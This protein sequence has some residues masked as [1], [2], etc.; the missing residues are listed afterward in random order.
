M[1]QSCMRYIRATS[2]PGFRSLRRFR[3]DDLA[4]SSRLPMTTST[5]TRRTS[6]AREL[7]RGA[8]DLASTGSSVHRY[9]DPVTAQFV[10]VDP[11]LS[12]T[13]QPYLYAG[14]DPVNRVDSSGDIS[15]PSFV[16]GCGVVTDI[17]HHW[18][19][20]TQGAIFVG[21][22]IAIGTCTVATDG[23]CGVI[24]AAGEVEVPAGTLVASAAIG[25]AEGLL[26]YSTDA[27]C[28]TAEGYL[29]AGGES[30]ALG[31]AEGGVDEFL[32]WLS[33]P[34]GTHTAP[35]GW[36]DTLVHYWTSTG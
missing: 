32:P 21:G 29:T 31:F 36:I 3:D 6:S 27:G 35:A 33:G 9:H 34:T 16:P 11:A 25:G 12:V 28:H 15:C 17:Q 2:G 18:R 19:G 5:C 7:G 13:G 23:I 4:R 8:Y 26:H 30:A 24:L 1:V 10:S 22:I 20:I 14:G